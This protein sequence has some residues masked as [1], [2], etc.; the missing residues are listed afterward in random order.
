VL[1]R[2][3]VLLAQALGLR[4]SDRAV[5]ACGLRLRST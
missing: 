3:R 5:R 4:E 2:A 1:R